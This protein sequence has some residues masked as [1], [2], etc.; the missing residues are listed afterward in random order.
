MRRS[1]VE[2]IPGVVPVESIILAEIVNAVWGVGRIG[3]AQVEIGEDGEL[4]PS[5]GARLWCK[6]HDDWVACVEHVQPLNLSAILR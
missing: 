1:Q 5:G 2:P 4:L 6:A 3:D